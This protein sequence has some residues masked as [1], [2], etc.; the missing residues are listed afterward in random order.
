[1]Q[2]GWHTKYGT[3]YSNRLGLGDC[4]Y[5]RQVRQKQGR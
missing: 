5:D 1:M 2:A 4:R 3:G